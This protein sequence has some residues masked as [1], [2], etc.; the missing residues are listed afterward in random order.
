MSK[1][2]GHDGEYPPLHEITANL[3]AAVYVTDSG[4][5]VV[6]SNPAMA[7]LHGGKS[8]EV[9]LNLLLPDGTQLPRESW[10]M[11]LAWVQQRE[12]SGTEIVVESPGGERRPFI[13]YCRPYHDPS[14]DFAGTIN[15]LADISSRKES[16]ARSRSLLHQFLHREKNEI[17]TIQSLLAGA[18]REATNPEAKEILADTARRVSAVAVAQ[19]AV[20]GLDSGTFRANS[21]LQLLGQVASQSFGR[22]LDLQMMPSTVEVANR[23]ALPLAIIMNELICNSV[24]HGRAGR[25]RVAVQVS[26]NPAEDQ[27]VLTVQDNGP[28]FVRPIAKRRASGL[29][30]VEGLARQ[31][32]GTLEVTA[33][34]GAR[35]VVRFNA[36]PPQ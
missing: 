10:P 22:N 15:L 34:Q 12:V 13:A 35:C 16:E 11:T 17:Q 21:L 5:A 30:L 19:S 2:S 3:P 28:G 26:L 1:P 4:G 24:K 9:T 25:S 27:A 31:L 36:M 20:D 23:A 18:H 7:E 14:G 8:P 32:G 29:G 6:W 33:D